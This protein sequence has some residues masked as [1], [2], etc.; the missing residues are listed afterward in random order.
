MRTTVCRAS[1]AFVLIAIAPLSFVDA[2]PRKLFARND[3]PQAGVILDTPTHVF[4][5]EFDQLVLGDRAARL[6]ATPR[7]RDLLAK[8]LA[9]VDRVCHLSEAQKQKLTLAGRGDLKRLD[10]RVETQRRQFIE[11]R[12]NGMLDKEHAATPQIAALHDAMTTGPFA[13]G[14]LFEK[15]LRTV[16]SP[17]QLERYEQPRRLA[18]HSTDRITVAN[19]RQLQELARFPRGV[20]RLVW[21][22]TNK[23]VGLVDAEKPVEICSADKLQTL[24]IIGAGRK[25]AAF[26]FSPERDVVAVGESTSASVMNLSTGQEV[27]LRTGNR[28]SVSFRADGQFVATGGFGTQST[29]WSAATGKRIRNF[30]SGPIAGEITPVFSPDGTLIALG[31]RQGWTRV[32]EVATGRWMRLFAASA[33]QELKFDPT[34]ERVAVAYVDGTLGVWNV[35]L[36][37]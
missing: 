13:E 33:S 18:P 28:P 31:N 1:L 12:A 20:S 29:L 24:R 30:D 34:G 6:A 5:D 27:A 36:G 23:E 15:T 35:S 9:A 2:A 16:L 10:D 25:F 3:P 22:R 19:A 14:S 21:S 11:D 7:L 32:F 17:T 37:R 8:R 4:A 26:D